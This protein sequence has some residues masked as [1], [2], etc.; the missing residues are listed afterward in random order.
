ML[1]MSNA[2]AALIGWIVGTVWI[3]LTLWALVGKLFGCLS[4]VLSRVYCRHCNDLYLEQVK[5]IRNMTYEIETM[6]DVHSSEIDEMRR[7][8]DEANMLMDR[9]VKHYCPNGIPLSNV[10]SGK[11]FDAVMHDIWAFREKAMEGE[12]HKDAK[13]SDGVK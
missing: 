7:Y 3:L 11:V 4:R 13:P 12:G 2:V 8:T 6:K 10:S 9:A 5:T 1:E